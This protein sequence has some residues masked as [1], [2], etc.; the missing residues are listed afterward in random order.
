MTASASREGG[1]KADGR[2]GHPRCVCCGLVWILPGWRLQRGK[3]GVRKGRGRGEEA[4]STLPELGHRQASLQAALQVG[5][6]RPRQQT[7]SSQIKQLIWH[8]D[9]EQTA[10]LGTVC[11]DTG[12]LHN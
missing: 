6:V 2:A 12:Q 4:S 9:R 5:S 1:S 8:W 10:L 3:E 11:P 7:D